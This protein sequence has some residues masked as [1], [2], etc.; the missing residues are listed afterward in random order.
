MTLSYAWAVGANRN[1]A[2]VNAPT[3]LRIKTDTLVHL[4]SI[5][6]LPFTY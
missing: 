5:S 6:P 1:Q 3:K 2:R 4:T